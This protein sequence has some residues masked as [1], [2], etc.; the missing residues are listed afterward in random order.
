M[1]FSDIRGERA[2]DVICEL[3]EPI[4]NIA[5]DEA[6]AD[7]F[8]AKKPPEGV[9]INDFLFGR[10]RRAYPALFKKHRGDLIRIAS[11]LNGC[12]PEEYAETL[13]MQKL[14]DDV[15][16]LMRDPYFR[17]FFIFVPNQSGGEASGPA[18]EN[19]AGHEQ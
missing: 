17:S 8:C 2:M 16:D 12:T 14:L 4:A 5:E 19:T 6:A 3:I 10:L 1:K 11:T 15:A 13:T 7:L 18:A 9:N